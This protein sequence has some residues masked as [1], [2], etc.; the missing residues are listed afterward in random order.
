MSPFEPLVPGRLDAEAAALRDTILETRAKVVDAIGLVA[1]DGSLRGPF[2][3]L[4]R[5]PVIGQVV[6]E[7]GLV[8]RSGSDLGPTVCEAAIL[9]IVHDWDC[10]FEWNAHSTLAFD[11]GVLSEDDIARIAGGG[12]PTDRVPAL[13]CEFAA[14]QIRYRGLDTATRASVKQEF[15]ERGMVELTIL[16]AYYELV[17]RLIRTCGAGA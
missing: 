6:Q 13:A 4:L 17:C 16:V 3:P 14:Q 5:T 1:P 2:D 11:A 12:R 8:V 9:T 7:L 15:G 10:T